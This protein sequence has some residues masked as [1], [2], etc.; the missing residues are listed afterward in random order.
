MTVLWRHRQ[1]PRRSAGF[2]ILELLVTLAIM[3]IVLRVALPRMGG[4]VA[5]ASFQSTAIALAAELRATRSAAMWSNT[6]VSVY[7]GPDGHSYWSGVHTDR[8]NLPAGFSLNLSGPGVVEA[9]SGA[10]SLRFRPDGS[11]SEGRFQL[12]GSSRSAAVT[13]DWLTGAM[14]IE[15]IN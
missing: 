4:T 3:A 15:W 14:H 7:V 5:R 11:A 6:E 9:A 12:S 8:Q 13:V 2:T 1:D 10:K